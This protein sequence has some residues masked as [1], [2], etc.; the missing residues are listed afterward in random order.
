[1]NALLMLAFVRAV[2]AVLTKRT[3]LRDGHG[4]VLA[5]AYGN[6]RRDDTP[7][8][9]RAIDLTYR[10]MPPSAEIMLSEGTFLVKRMLHV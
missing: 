2:W 4:G 6:G 9:Q 8:L 10:R 5:L 7:N 3:V 1:M